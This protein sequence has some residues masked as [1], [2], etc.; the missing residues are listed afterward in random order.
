MRW[1]SLVFVLFL[2]PSLVWGQENTDYRLG[3]GDVIDIIV[4]EEQDLSMQ[5][6]VSSSGLVNYP[7]LGKIKVSGQTPEQV[8][9]SLEHGLA[10]DYLIDPKIAVNVVS[11]RQIFV[12]GEVEKPGAYAYQPGL[13]IEKAVALAGGFSQRAYDGNITLTPGNGADDK[14]K[15]SL[16]LSIDPGDIIMVGRRFF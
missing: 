13:T 8:K 11:Y 10:G 6:M 7:Y 3:P 12:N 14:S 2:V 5:V 16:K 4:Y 9:L 1:L 15:V